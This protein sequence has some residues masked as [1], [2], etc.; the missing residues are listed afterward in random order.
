M[1]V[2]ILLNSHKVRRGLRKDGI[3]EKVRIHLSAEE[4]RIVLEV[5]IA[6]AMK[7]KLTPMKYWQKITILT[8][9]LRKVHR[10]HH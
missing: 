5:S 8:P 4:T 9:Q 3:K 6:M 1:N 7:K 10:I 2:Q